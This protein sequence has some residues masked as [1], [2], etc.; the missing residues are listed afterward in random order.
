VFT[1]SLLYCRIG[2]TEGSQTIF[3]FHSF[4]FLRAQLSASPL[5]DPG[6]QLMSD[7]ALSAWRT[8]L[9]RA[10]SLQQACDTVCRMHGLEVRVHGTFPRDLAIYVCNHLG[11]ID[12]VAICSVIPCAPIAK[13]EVASWPC[14]GAL[15]RRLGVIFVQRN[16]T[17]SATRALLA[18]KRRLEAGVS[19]LNFPE[20][21]T[22][23]GEL[24]PFRRGIFGLATRLGVPIV[25]L[26]MHFDEPDLCWVDDDSFIVHYS[27]AMIGKAHCVGVRVGPQMY[28]RS[29]ESPSQFA[30][31]VRGWIASARD[32]VAGVKRLPALEG[33]TPPRR[34]WTAPA[35]LA[36]DSAA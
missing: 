29:Q 17:V 14:I 26:A 16:D 30:S 21:T 18:A 11:Y 8:P 22:T 10:R 9:A 6:V 5:G 2:F 4:R 33:V 1:R 31:R 3:V 15:A 12:P 23:R 19:I 32:E 24:L 13:V 27:T 36:D 28:A 35:P 20:G 34:V 7:V 25:P